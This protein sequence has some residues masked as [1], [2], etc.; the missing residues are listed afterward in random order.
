M[1]I[2]FLNYFCASILIFTN[3]AHAEIPWNHW[4]HQNDF[5]EQDLSHYD[6]THIYKCSLNCRKDYKAYEFVKEPDGNVYIALKSRQGQLSKLNNQK[7]TIKDRIELGTKNRHSSFDIDGESFWYGFRAKLPKGT[8]S[9]N[10]EEIL[11]AQFKQIQKDAKKKDCHFQPSLKIKIKRNLTGYYQI[12]GSF[13]REKVK[14]S[15]GNIEVNGQK[16]VLNDKWRSFVI[17]TKFA[18]DGWLKIYV[19]GKLVEHFV[20]DTLY[21]TKPKHCVQPVRKTTYIYRI[22]VYR[23]TQ[24]SK[25]TSN[26]EETFDEIHFDDFVSGKTKEYVEDFLKK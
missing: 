1:F 24:K 3:V 19:D 8:E 21:N 26:Y 17:G 15:K 10:A 20:G 5:S 13:K 2:K 23:G 7:K 18:D 25:L 4:K 9:L 14:Q 12:N 6:Q 16:H 11:F 22:G